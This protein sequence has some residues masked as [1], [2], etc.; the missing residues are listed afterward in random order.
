MGFCAVRG[1]GWAEEGVECASVGAGVGS[2]GMCVT[3]ALFSGG[4]LGDRLGLRRTGLSMIS[5]TLR[6]LTT[7]RA[8]LPRLSISPTSTFVVLMSNAFHRD[9]AA[10]YS[11]FWASID[12][13]V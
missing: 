12:S 13:S 2:A 7:T 11:C 5:G 6:V 10:P 3:L 9:S 1:R 8:I 4:R